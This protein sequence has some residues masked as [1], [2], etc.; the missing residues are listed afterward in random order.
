MPRFTPGRMPGSDNRWEPDLTE[1]KKAFAPLTVVNA[2]SELPDID[3]GN[4]QFGVRLSFASTII[5][6]WDFSVNYYDGLDSVGVLRSKVAQPNVMITR[7]FPRFR[8]IGGDFS[9]TWG[10]MEFHGEAAAHFTDDSD[11]DDDCWE[12]IAGIN[13]TFDSLP[14]LEELRVT[15]EYAGESTSSTKRTRA[16]IFSVPLNTSVL[17]R[18]HYWAT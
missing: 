2:G 10:K 1:E 14:L 4:V 11:M 18:A 8:E 6:G 5:E 17:S 16:A 9:T 7:V 15:A 3:V 13:Y 12:Y